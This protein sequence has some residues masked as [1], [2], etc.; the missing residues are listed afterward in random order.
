MHWHFSEHCRVEP[1]DRN[2]FHADFGVGAVTLEMDKSLEC[3]VVRGSEEPILGWVS[4]GY[5]RRVPATTLIGRWTG[6]GSLS[7]TTSI[8]VAPC[9]RVSGD[10]SQG[11]ANAGVRTATRPSG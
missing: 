11:T 9:D 6:D 7:L 2:R 3:S 8:S 4:R 5:H 10:E 1:L